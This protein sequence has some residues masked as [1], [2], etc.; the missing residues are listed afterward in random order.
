MNTRRLRWIAVVVLVLS[1]ALN[2]LDR[3]ILPALMPT[4]RAEFNVSSADLGT[5]VAAFSLTYALASPLMGLLIDR[6]GLRW[7]GAIVVGFWSAV[8]LSTG[9]VTGFTSLL[10]FRALLGVAE[11]GG[12]PLTGKGFAA[13]LEP[14]GV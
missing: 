13:Y 8:G 9:F 2:Y 11:A 6:V 5:V 14:R 3:M 1:S 10:A 12:I 7:G 4:L